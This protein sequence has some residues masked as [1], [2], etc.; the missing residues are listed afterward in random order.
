ML[1]VYKSLRRKLASMKMFLH[2]LTYL[3]FLGVLTFVLV[4]ALSSHVHNSITSSKQLAKGCRVVH[5]IMGET[6]IPLKPQRIVTLWISIL[7]NTLAL[8]VKPVGSTYYTGEP[9]PEYLRDQINGVEFVGNLTEP[10]LEKILLLNP[11]L[12]LV[13]S[14]LQNIYEHLSYI[15][16]TVMM[17]FPIPPPS[18]KQQLQELATVLDKEE[19]ANHL[20]DEYWQRIEQLKQSLGELRC[21]L[22]V[23]VASVTSSGEIYAYGEKHLVGTILNDIGLQRPIS[24]RGDFYYI[25]NISEERLS[26]LDGDVLFVL[27]NEEQRTRELLERLQQKPLWQQLNAVQQNR[28]YLVDK[29]HWHGIDTLAAYAVIDDLLKYLVKIS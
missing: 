9:F 22:Q 6:C 19:T 29:G 7:G 21:Q 11:D 3:L 2:R 10:N 18:W 26:D 12:I 25:N 24:Q 15:A 5:H 8:N 23:S 4:S 1:F 28:V 27:T 13:N 17:E 20:M 14:R 16:P